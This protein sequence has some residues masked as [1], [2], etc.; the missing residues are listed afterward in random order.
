MR[1]IKHIPTLLL[2]IALGTGGCDREDVNMGLAIDA[3]LDALKAATLSDENVNS[4]A[5]D[6]ARVSDQKNQLAP[7]S[8]LV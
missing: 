5:A 6:A 2:L 1:R 7:A 4:I 8:S 3:G